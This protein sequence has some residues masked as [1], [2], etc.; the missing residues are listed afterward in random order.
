MTVVMLTSGRGGT[1]EAHL[2]AQQSSPEGEARLPGAHEHPRRPCRPEGPAGQGTDSAVGLIARVHGR[3]WFERFRTEGRRVSAGDLW[4]V[5]VTEPGAEQPHV[6][7]AIG[8][9]V[10]PAV[11]RNR[12][13]RRLRVLVHRHAA[14]LAPGYYLIGARPAVASR[15]FE[16]LNDM[17][18]RVLNRIGEEL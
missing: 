7:Y 18:Q 15:S 14:L 11:V 17:M 2:S 5:V 6:A 10:G 13:R 1:G 4:C 16:E 3:R 8:R 9:T 12:I